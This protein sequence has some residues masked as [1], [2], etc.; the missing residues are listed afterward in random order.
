MCHSH[1]VCINS[2]PGNSVRG[3]TGFVAIVR[4]SEPTAHKPLGAGSSFLSAKGFTAAAG[5]V[6]C[7]YSYR[8]HVCGFLHKS[9]RPP[10]TSLYDPQL[11]TNM[12]PSLSLHQ[13]SARPQSPEPQGRYSFE[14]EGFLKESASCTSGRF[15]LFGPGTGQLRWICLPQARMRIARCSLPHLTPRWRGMCRH[16]TD[17]QPGCMHFLQSIYC[18]WC[19]A[20]SGKRVLWW[21]SLPRTGRT[22]LGPPDLIELLVAPPCPIPVRKDLLSQVSGLVWHPKPELRSLVWLLRG[23]QRSWEPWIIMC[24]TCFRK[25]GHPLQGVCM[26]WNGECLW[27]DALCSYRPGYMLRGGCYFGY[28]NE[29]RFG[30]PFHITQ[31]GLSPPSKHGREVCLF[32]IYALQPAGLL[33][34]PSPGFTSW[35]FSPWLLKCCGWVTIHV[36]ATSIHVFAASHSKYSAQPFMT[37]VVLSALNSMFFNVQLI[38]VPSSCYV[39][40]L[41]NTVRLSTHVERR[42]LKAGLQLIGGDKPMSV[43]FRHVSVLLLLSMAWSDAVW[44][45]GRRM[46]GGARDGD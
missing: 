10:C 40:L 21:Y 37:I 14:E 44:G 4:T 36:Y 22:S 3:H 41:L 25:C 43:A 17:Q 38:G 28:L 13:S 30:M 16:H 42:R 46:V 2:S 26:L 18:H 5:T 34:I 31:Q 32:R 15:G 29:P 35:T 12:E 20:Q 24:S 19:Y 11:C 45:F 7:A 8:Q 6:A 33:R 23:Y 1:D 39:S 9:P 27:N